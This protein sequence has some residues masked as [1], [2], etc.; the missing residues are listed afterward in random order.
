MGGAPAQQVPENPVAELVAEGPRQDQQREQPE[1]APRLI[2]QPEHGGEAR[3]EGQ[4]QT[5]DARGGLDVIHPTKVSHRDS[6]HRLLP[7][8]WNHAIF[9]NESFNAR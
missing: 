5:V 9:T 2:Q 8:S 4:L 1:G 7:E 3:Q 6:E